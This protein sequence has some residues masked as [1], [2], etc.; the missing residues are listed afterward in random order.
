M[1]DGGIIYHGLIKYIPILG[2]MRYPIKFFFLTVFAI[3]LLA[4]FAIATLGNGETAASK[5][6]IRQCLIISALSIAVIAGIIWHVFAHPFPNEQSWILLRNGAYRV[7]FLA[8]MV[9]VM[10]V[11]GKIRNI[12]LQMITGLLLLVLVWLDVVTHVPR[13]NPTIE[14]SAFEPGLLT[15]YFNPPLRNGAARALRNGPTYDFFFHHELAD[16]YKDYV[17]RRGVL[18]GDCNI[19]DGIPTPDGFYSLYLRDQQ[20]MFSQFFLSPTNAFPSG[21]ADFLSASVESHPTKLFGWQK[22][23]SALPFYTFGQRPVFLE[24]SNIPT[25]LLETNFDPRQIVYLPP[26]SKK[27]VN[28]S[29]QVHGTIHLRDIAA[30]RWDFDTEAGAAALLVLSQAYY[31]PWRAYVDGKP[32]EILPA[33]FAFQAVEVPAGR[34]QVEF[35]YHDLFFQVGGWIS[36][37][38]LIGCIAFLLPHRG[39][40]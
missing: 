39:R 18:F 6:S 36:V 22:R 15:H 9:G 1:G 32:T 8:L 25:A 16:P 13:Q 24:I 30:E 37:A 23:P 29:G 26:E 35:I 40:E 34:H 2:F 27:Y 21:F 17:G 38:T 5:R 12:R 7:L 31:H 19:M 11:L 3:P 14:S 28:A 33:N 20:Q 4:A 10:L